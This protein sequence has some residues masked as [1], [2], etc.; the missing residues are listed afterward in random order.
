MNE[1]WTSTFKLLLIQINSP[2]SKDVY[3]NIQQL[4]QIEGL[5]LAF[6]NHEPHTLKSLLIQIKQS[7]LRCLHEH[8]ETIKRLPCKFLSPNVIGCSFT[9]KKSVGGQQYYA[10]ANP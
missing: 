9:K 3:T 10:D 1:S 5:Q 2:N 6:T 8:P 4:I 7:K